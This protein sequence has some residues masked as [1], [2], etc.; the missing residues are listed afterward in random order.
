MSRFNMI[1]KKNLSKKDIVL[2]IENL[3]SQERN[4]SADIKKIKRLAM[5]KNIKLGSLRKKFCEKCYSLFNSENSKTRIRGN[6]KIVRCEKCN[7]ISR[8]QM[9]RFKK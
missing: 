2:T 9:Q 4:I 7:Y 8:W 3:F 1:S 6:F 5:S